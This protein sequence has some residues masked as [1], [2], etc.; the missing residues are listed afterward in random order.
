MGPGLFIPSC[1]EQPLI[2][3][4]SGF[5]LDRETWRH[6]TQELTRLLTD[7]VVRTTSRTIDRVI[8]VTAIIRT[9][10]LKPTLDCQP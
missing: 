3:T 7:D 10:R 1:F 2:I 4:I 6:L 9:R 5:F 8:V